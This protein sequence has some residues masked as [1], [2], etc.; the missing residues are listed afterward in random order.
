M[1]PATR[2]LHAGR[3]SAAEG[4][5][6]IN[7]PVMRASTILFP[8]VEA[9]DAADKNRY[10]ELSY[11]RHGTSGS[12]AL[13]SALAE[14]EGGYRAIALPSGLAA[15]SAALLSFAKPGAHILVTDSAYGPT[16]NF[17]QK[18]LE[19]FGVMVEY[20]DPLAGGEIAALIRP[21]TAAIY[22]ESPGTASFEVQD[23]PAIAAAVAGRDIPV[24]NDNTWA[25]PCL[26]PSFERGVDISLHA[27]TKY[28][29]GHSDAM[30]GVIV[31]NE[32]YW[33]KVRE[34]VGLLGYAASPDDCYLALR[35]LRT[36][37]VR[38]EKH[39]ASALAVARWLQGRG[40]V[41][42]V[43]FPALE[44][45]P[46]HALWKRDFSGASGLLGFRL[47][48]AGRNEAVRFC[49]ALKLFGIGAS[50][51]GYESLV[52]IPK[53]TRSAS[54]IAGEGVLLR[55]HVGLEDPDDLIADLEA[56][57][58]VVFP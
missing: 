40:E 22:C 2:I 46:G 36:L 21:E 30:L 28:I 54:T 6:P 9:Y 3:V 55:I 25:T 45:D 12:A 57:M 56:A 51:G 31:C 38:L 50:W 26:F 48:V 5:Y 41:D 33:L 37:A 34:M 11:G 4:G 16:R 27:G 24:L 23:I 13:E 49:N 1:K 52:S 35:G 7:P 19:P 39:Q 53:P 42:R 20:Y 15:I 18:F 43:L 44:S 8:T 58:K 32:R 47:K 10:S 29:V 14:M 17:C